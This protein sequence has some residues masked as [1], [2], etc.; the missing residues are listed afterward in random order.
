MKL[1]PKNTTPIRHITNLILFVL[2][3]VTLPNIV[4]Y[5][6][7]R[8]T[9]FEFNVNHIS[10]VYEDV[11][12]GDEFV[13]VHFVREVRPSTGVRASSVTELVRFEEN[14]PIE[15][16][17]KKTSDYIYQQDDNEVRLVVD[18]PDNLPVGQ[19]GF[20]EYVIIYPYWGIEKEK[21]FL[22]REAMFEVLD[23]NK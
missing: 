22:A 14:I 8:V 11:C 1:I 7:Y 16:P 9:P 12:I 3:A 18:I 19:Y 15:T 5:V 2:I 20:N 13:I 23:C 21:I 6:V 10:R 4:E 17:F